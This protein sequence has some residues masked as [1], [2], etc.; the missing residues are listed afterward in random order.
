MIDNGYSANRIKPLKQN[1]YSLKQNISKN[2]SIKLS[3]FF[4]AFVVV[5]KISY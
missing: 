2:E 1:R 3:F 4:N 5:G